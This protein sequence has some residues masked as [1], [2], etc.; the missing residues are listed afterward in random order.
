MHLIALI[1]LYFLP[2]FGH[3]ITDN[4]EHAVETFPTYS[5]ILDAP[6]R[7]PQF[8]QSVLRLQEF[9]ETHQFSEEGEW[10]SEENKTV[11]EYSL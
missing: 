9:F 1:L 11:Y 5:L 10:I 6:F 4:G 2:N 8:P 3:F 7:G